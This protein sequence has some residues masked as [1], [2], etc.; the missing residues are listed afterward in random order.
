MNVQLYAPIVSQRDGAF[1]IRPLKATLLEARALLDAGQR[2]QGNPPLRWE[3]EIGG[4]LIANR[5]GPV[6]Y[7]VRVVEVDIPG[8]TGFAMAG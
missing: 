8:V 2:R 5:Y 4:G 7:E 6:T 3:N 1:D